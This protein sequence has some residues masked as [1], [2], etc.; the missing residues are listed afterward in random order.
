[1]QRQVLPKN[2]FCVMFDGLMSHS[3]KIISGAPTFLWARL[4]RKLLAS[5]DQEKTIYIGYLSHPNT[6]KRASQGSC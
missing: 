4:M 2:D 6:G 3:Y 1:M 5:A